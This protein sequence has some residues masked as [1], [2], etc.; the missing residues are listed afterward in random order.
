VLHHTAEAAL[1]RYALSLVAENAWPN[2]LIAKTPNAAQTVEQIRDALRQFF[3]WAKGSGDAGDLL[4]CCTEA[5]MPQYVR[6]TLRVIH[7]T[8]EPPPLPPVPSAAAA[9]FDD[10]EL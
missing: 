7:I 10:E 9:P 1:R 4:G 5:E 8:V 3:G 2:H 6:D